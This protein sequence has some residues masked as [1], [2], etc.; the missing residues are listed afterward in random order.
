M[1]VYS[2]NNANELQSDNWVDID[3]QRDIHGTWWGGLCVWTHAS[4]LAYHA[5]SFFK[6]QISYCSQRQYIRLSYYYRHHLCFSS[7]RGKSGCGTQ[8]YMKLYFALASRTCSVISL[9]SR[10]L[11]NLEY[12]W[13][14]VWNIAMWD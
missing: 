13:N 12:S 14:I 4:I 8:R 2:C 9:L 7:L 3:Q 6:L 1:N 11:L 5:L 10:A